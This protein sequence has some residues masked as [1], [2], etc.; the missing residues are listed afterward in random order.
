MLPGTVK[1]GYLRL[2]VSIFAS[3]ELAHRVK[4]TARES[5]HDAD[6]Y[7]TCT[8]LLL[9]VRLC[10]HIITRLCVPTLPHSVPHHS[11]YKLSTYKSCSRNFQFEDV[12]DLDTVLDRFLRPSHEDRSWSV[13]VYHSRLRPT[14]NHERAA[15]RRIQPQLLSLRRRF[16]NRPRAVLEDARVYTHITRTLPLWSDS[17]P[18]SGAR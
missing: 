17:S 11:A 3:T 8:M 4:R 10:V 13:L 18:F 6:T 1:V 5:L 7:L 15:P 12:S 9:F 2:T 16:R 14:C